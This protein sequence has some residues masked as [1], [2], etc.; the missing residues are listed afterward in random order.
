MV[1]KSLRQ[2]ALLAATVFPLLAGSV[3]LQAQTLSVEQKLAALEQRSGGRLGVALI[4]TADGSQILYRGDERFAMCSTSKVMAAAAVLKQSES[5]HDLLNQ[6]IEIKKGDLTNY[7]PIAEKHVGR[8][9]SLSELSAAALQYSDNVAMNKLI[10]QLG[11]PQGVTAFARK[12]GDE[13]FRLDRTEPT[14]NTAIPG[15]PRD[16]TS[17]RAMA[18]TLRNLTLGKALGDAQRAQLVTWMK[19]NTT[20]TASI[21]AGLPASW[22]VGDK[23]GSG[24]YGTTNDIAV[25][26]PKDRAPLVLVTYFTQPQPEAESRRDVLA[27][28]AKIVTEGL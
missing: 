21:Q 13:T 23:T 10:A 22:V 9:M 24:D 14:L 15:D 1:K 3:S 28:A 25:I 26:W 7:N 27:S 2:F 12:I 19:G 5:Q 4:D 20:G 18:Q 11:G 16:T 8:S 17:P 6:R